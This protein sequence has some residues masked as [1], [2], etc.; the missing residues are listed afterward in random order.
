MKNENDEIYVKVH[1]TFPEGD[2]RPASGEFLWAKMIPG[3]PY[4][5]EI[6]NIPFMAYNIHHGDIVHAMPQGEI[7]R[8]VNAV[9]ETGGCMTLRIF[10]EPEQS[11]EV[12]PL[13][14]MLREMGVGAERA[15]AFL[16]SLS[17]PID[18]CVDSVGQLLSDAEKDGLVEWEV[19]QDEEVQW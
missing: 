12:E 14:Q 10:H 11:S 9:I 5:Y 4:H 7:E 3:R 1:V 16:V 18:V 6:D 19:A 2:P 13:L 8:E 17:V 15:T